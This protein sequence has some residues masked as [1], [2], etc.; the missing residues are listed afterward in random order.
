MQLDRYHGDADILNF[1]RTMSG[2]VN[3]EQRQFDVINNIDSNCE[4]IT[5]KSETE[6]AKDGYV[7]DS[8]DADSECLK[9]YKMR[10]A[11]EIK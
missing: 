3:D 6:Y 5:D 7:A 10:F 8:Y 2:K 11:V 4:G 1:L 9:V